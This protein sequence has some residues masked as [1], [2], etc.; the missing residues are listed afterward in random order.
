MH[1]QRARILSTVQYA[2]VFV[3]QSCNVNKS[4]AQNSPKAPEHSAYPVL[5][6]VLI[7]APT[8]AEIARASTP[9]RDVE[10]HDNIIQH[11]HKS[12]LR[13]QFLRPWANPSIQDSQCHVNVHPI[14][15]FYQSP[16]SPLSVLEQS[17]IAPQGFTKAG[18]SR[19]RDSSVNGAVVGRIRR[20]QG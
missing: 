19:G 17:D 13:P 16:A 1:L 7:P 18:S 4:S 11:R 2:Q 10:I 3:S 14:T 15:E 6:P 5:I 9:Q 8:P 20:D 12:G